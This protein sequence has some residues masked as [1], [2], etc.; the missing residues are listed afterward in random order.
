MMVAITGGTGFIGRRLVRELA[1]ANHRVRILTRTP[2][3][4]HT[5]L[6]NVSYFQGDLC[7]GG[8][9]TDFLDG[10]EVLFH[11]AGEVSDASRMER[12]HVEGT[13]RLIEAASGRV[14]H[15]VQLSSTG[16][17]GP[18]RYGEITERNALFPVGTYE[19]SKVASDDLVVRASAQGAFTHAI[20]RPSIVFGRDMPNRSLFS[21]LRMI[22]RKLFFFIGRPGASANYIHVDNVIHAL[23]LC[24][25]SPNASGKTF[26]L[27]DH[28]SF[29][30]FVRQMALAL[31][32]SPP[33]L[34]L[35]EGLVRLSAHLLGRI[36]GFPLT[37]S[38]VD[39][40]TSF[41][42][43]PIDQI[44]NELGYRHTITM[45]EGIGDLVCGYREH[46]N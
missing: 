43:Y 21:M 31:E 8:S 16:A 36:P 1:V 35:P 9:L 17:F 29:E 39:A 3:D 40:L 22:E 20:L 15:W 2:L 42:R 32:V 26:N 5:Q 4:H 41:V 12:L 25:F 33:T 18:R 6:P 30:D 34:R 28:L 10:A 44:E 38:R 19:T 23:M 14:S 13:G 24:G 27:S 7:D 45:A 37:S 11:C 46:F